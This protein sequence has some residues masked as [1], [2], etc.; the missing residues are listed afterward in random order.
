MTWQETVMASS[1]MV[2][3]TVVVVVVI[4][5]VAA[6]WRARMSVARE[7]AYRHLA[8]EATAAQQ[9][10][11][12]RLESVTRELASIRERTGHLENLLREVDEPW[13]RQDPATR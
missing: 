4:A 10:T 11:A 3:A 12:H 2:L 8:A 5:Q 7:E 13:A 9:S 1:T 6:T